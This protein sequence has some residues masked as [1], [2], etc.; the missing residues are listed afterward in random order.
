M[1]RE[2]D[3]EQSIL[4]LLDRPELQSPSDETRTAIEEARALLE[5][6]GDDRLAEIQNTV[7]YIGEQVELIRTV[8]DGLCREFGELKQAIG[9][10]GKQK[11]LF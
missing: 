4:W 9:K 10:D 2:E 8:L 11:K 5:D 1:S 3:L 7:V 6:D